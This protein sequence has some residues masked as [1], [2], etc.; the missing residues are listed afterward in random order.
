[1]HESF[2]DTFTVN[3]MEHLL[4]SNNILDTDASTTTSSA[5]NVA[6]LRLQVGRGGRG[7]ESDEGSGED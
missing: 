4:E 5:T 3:D 7:L 1:M 2:S 6:S